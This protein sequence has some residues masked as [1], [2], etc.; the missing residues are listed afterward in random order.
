MEIGTYSK[1]LIMYFIILLTW[2]LQYEL[3]PFETY[4][5]EELELILETGFMIFTFVIRFYEL[6]IQKK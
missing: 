3:E 6:D 5:T 1:L 2:F 4:R